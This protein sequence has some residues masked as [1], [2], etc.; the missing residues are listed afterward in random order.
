MDKA[1]EYMTAH[2]YLWE[3]KLIA[4]ALLKEMGQNAISSINIKKTIPSQP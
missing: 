1:T 3:K 4:V 2:W